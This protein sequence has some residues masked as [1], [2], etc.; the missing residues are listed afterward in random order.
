MAF[1]QFP[2][3][4]DGVYDYEDFLVR[5]DVVDGMARTVIAKSW[6]DIGGPETVP[7]HLKAPWGT[8]PTFPPKPPKK[9]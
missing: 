1:K 9:G 6:V 5:Y 4:P 3:V 2:W 7:S 8:F